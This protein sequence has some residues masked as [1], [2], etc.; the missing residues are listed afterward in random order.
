MSQ[1]SEF[2]HLN[3]KR[4]AINIDPREQ[5][6]PIY[7]ADYPYQTIGGQSNQKIYPTM[8][9]RRRWPVIVLIV[10]LVLGLLGAASY[11]SSSVF[12][13]TTNLPQRS[14]QVTGTPTLV[15]KNDT[16]KVHIQRGSDSTVSVKASEYTGFFDNPDNIQVTTTQNGN[17]IDVIVTEKDS[18]H[19][20]ISYE[21]VDLDIVLPASSNIQ[22]NLDTGNIEISDVSGQMN[23]ETDTGS[24]DIKR[25]DISGNSSFNVDTGSIDFENGSISGQTHFSTDTGKIT[26]D[27][28]L[29]PNGNYTFEA[30]MGSIDLT[31][32]ADSSFSLDARTDTGKVNNDFASSSVGSNPTSKLQIITDT[33]SISLRKK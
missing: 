25:A 6:G 23:L 32:P 28:S 30:D 22:A 9:R 4:S 11:L 19:I 31:L 12:G 18:F 20:G 27:G 13:K 16:G 7:Q 21:K 2:E 1:Q 8:R 33:G 14:F 26:F 3:E 17:E 15:I 5:P 24:I 10:V 29:A